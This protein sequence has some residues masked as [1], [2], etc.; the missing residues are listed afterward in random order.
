MFH[1]GA[2]YESIDPAGA[3]VGIA[4]VPEQT[5]F[6]SGDDLRVPTALPFL[7]GAGALI[8]DASGAQAEV[9]SPSLR[10]FANQDVEPIVL[11]PTWG[12]PPESLF[13]PERAIPLVADEA[14]N[15][16]ANSDPA[17]A[18][19]HYG[20]VVLADGAQNPVTGDYFTV[21]CTATVQ[22]AVGT[23]TNGT[24]AF[25][26][27]LPAGRYGVIGMRARSTD[28]VF[29][30]LV[31]PEQIARPGVP[32]VN[33]IGDLDPSGFRWGNAGVWGEFPH[34]NPPTLDVLGGTAA[35]QVVFLDLIRI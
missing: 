26:Q 32:V 1:I 35:A 5:L 22:Q 12:S 25:G 2:F 13:H 6:T 11:A 8:N 29:A 21:R 15:F 34:T 4:A 33:A 24:L 7:I 18:A 23:W 20:L 9:Q 30:R 28:G 14:I 19:A 16:Y 3:L 10:I 31:F 27:T 17:A